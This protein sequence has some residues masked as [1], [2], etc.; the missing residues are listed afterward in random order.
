MVDRRTQVEDTTTS[1][2]MLYVAI[3]RDDMDSVRTHGSVRPW[4][5]MAPTANRAW[6]TLHYDVQE[7]LDRA[8]WGQEERGRI[9]NRDRLVVIPFEISAEGYGHFMVTGTLQSMGGHLRWHGDLP[10]LAT[11]RQREVILAAQQP[12]LTL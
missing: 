9:P 4:H 6:V 8:L 3:D 2:Q 7:A 11:N 1:N 12:A 10:L 5:V